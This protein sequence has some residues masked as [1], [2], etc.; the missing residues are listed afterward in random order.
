[1]MMNET[2]R[3]YMSSSYFI[4]LSRSSSSSS[5][6][7]SCSRCWNRLS[8]SFK[9]A[10][11]SLHIQALFFSLAGWVF[12]FPMDVVKTRIQA[13]EPS[14]RGTYNTVIS[15]VIQSYREEGLRVFFRGLSPTLIRCVAL[16]CLAADPLCS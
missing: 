6:S 8:L 9:A 2:V 13:S 1:M 11:C 10:F 16:C 4:S 7:T 5:S 15:T 3:S 12:T 14:P